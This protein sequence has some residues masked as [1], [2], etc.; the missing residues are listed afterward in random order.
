MNPWL[1]L[2]YVHWM[3]PTKTPVLGHHWAILQSTTVIWSSPQIAE[4]QSKLFAFFANRIKWRI[5][6]SQM[7]YHPLLTNQLQVATG[8]LNAGQPVTGTSWNT[9]KV[10]VKA[11]QANK[12]MNF[13]LK[14]TNP[15]FLSLNTATLD[16]E[17]LVILI[18]IFYRQS[19][20][21]SLSTV[22]INPPPV[23]GERGCHR[24]SHKQGL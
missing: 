11:F 10:P 1:K 23:E 24:T 17:C 15:S 2:V 12:V 18:I 20:E 21:I 4:Y 3:G 19:F 14:D 13:T 7:L 9:R 8:Q 6:G 16:D 5:S 22:Q